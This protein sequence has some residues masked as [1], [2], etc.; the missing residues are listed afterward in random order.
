MKKRDFFLE[1]LAHEAYRHKAWVFNM[2]TQ[3]RP[4]ERE[5]NSVPYLLHRGETH[6]Y[7]YGDHPISE[8]ATENTIIDDLE[9]NETPFSFK[10]TLRL[11][12]G[13]IPNLKEDITTTYGNL[14]FNYIALIYPFGDKINYVNGKIDIKKIEKEIE[15][16]LVTDPGYRK[17]GDFTTSDPITVSEYLDFTD[18]LLS[19][20]GFSQLVVPSASE[21]ALQ[22]HPDVKK[23]RAELIEKYKDQL[24]DPAIVAKIEKE[25][26][27]LDKEWIKGDLAEGFYQTSE[28][29]SYGIVRKKMFLMHGRE[30]PFDTDPT[31]V[32]NAL[33]EGWDLDA[34][35]AMVNSLREGS[36]KR[37]A[38][39]Q[40]GGVASKT[41]NRM[42]QNTRITQDDCG[43]VLGM[44]VTVDAKTARQYLGFY[45]IER[46]KAV[47]ITE[48]NVDGLIG[49]TLTL[50]SPMFCKTPRANYC[51][52]CMGD[53][54][55]QNPTGLASLAHAVGSKMMDLSM[56]AAHGKELKTT[57]FDMK[58]SFS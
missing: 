36:Y 43:S 29:K 3:T 27:A 37:G 7:F 1:A 40:L 4:S 16:R 54:I 22:T 48:E 50:R 28:G 31:F 56:Q 35:P 51:K 15:R 38:E 10:E 58:R 18:A 57:P 6:Y 26:I 5:V 47:R 33:T 42:F 52:T 9:V 8:A 23:R 25:L 12:A 13:E 34:L 20:E 44:D 55:S 49:K 24:H 53:A 30:A 14:L 39:T 46:G 45:Y 21:K 32:K 19:L 17:A 11:K 41:I 2:F